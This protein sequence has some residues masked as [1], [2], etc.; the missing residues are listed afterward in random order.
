MLLERKP[1]ITLPRESITS[2]RCEHD[3]PNG[4]A[5]ECDDQA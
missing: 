2:A 3:R 1:V 5:C 4:K